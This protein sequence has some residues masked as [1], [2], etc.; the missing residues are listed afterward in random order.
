MPQPSNP[1]FYPSVYPRLRHSTRRL[2]L[3]GQPSPQ[4]LKV[5]WSGPYF[6]RPLIT[7][8]PKRELSPQICKNFLNLGSHLA[9]TCLL[10][11]HFEIFRIEML[12]CSPFRSGPLD[13]TYTHFRFFR[14]CFNLECS[15][16]PG[17]LRSD[18]ST[19]ATQCE[20]GCRPKPD[21]EHWLLL[22]TVTFR[23]TQLMYSY[24]DDNDREVVMPHKV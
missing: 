21:S 15:S 6:S 9:S 11:F 8:T 4:P 18:T 23:G 20:S 24:H 14:V 13:F 17:S 7:T 12:A 2:S 10:P 19:I 5:S 22:S 16:T 3:L 1:P